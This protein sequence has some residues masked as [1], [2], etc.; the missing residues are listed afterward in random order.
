M[1]DP[2]RAFALKEAFAEDFSGGS[3]A[4]GDGATV[5]FKQLLDSDEH[6]PAGVIVTDDGNLAAAL[7]DNETFKRVAVPEEVRKTKTRQEKAAE[8]S[9][10]DGKDGH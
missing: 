6:G 7:E 4:F 10:T 1:T 2:R 3:M 8:P 9:S 5:D